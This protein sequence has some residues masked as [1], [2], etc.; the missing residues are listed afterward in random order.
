MQQLIQTARSL[1][2]E[3]RQVLW[4]RLSTGQK[5]MSQV[6]GAIELLD[7]TMLQLLLAWGAFFK[8]MIRISI[9][10]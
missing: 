9:Y 3:W 5:K 1:E 2:A 7:F 6:M 4:G 10:F 8:L